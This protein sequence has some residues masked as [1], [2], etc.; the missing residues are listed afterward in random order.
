M[1]GKV[2]AVC[3]GKVKNRPKREQPEICLTLGVGVGGARALFG[4]PAEEDVLRQ[5]AQMHDVRRRL[6]A[7]LTQRLA[8]EMQ[9]GTGRYGEI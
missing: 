5:L 3:L 7:D 4:E 2:E 9:G 6:A 1:E 8:W